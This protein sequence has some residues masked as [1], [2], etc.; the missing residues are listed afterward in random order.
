MIGVRTKIV[1]KLIGG[2]QQATLKDEK[3]LPAWIHWE[4]IEQALDV[5]TDEELIIIA[6]NEV[7]DKKGLNIFFN[8]LMESPFA[9]LFF[10]QG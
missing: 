10:E 1:L 6:E 4:A 8:L 5:Y 9:D 3:E 2:L 7:K